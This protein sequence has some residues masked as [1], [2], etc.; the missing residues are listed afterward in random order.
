MLS[1]GLAMFIAI[2][3]FGIPKEIT[4]EEYRDNLSKRE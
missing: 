3:F 1:F 4:E 2:A